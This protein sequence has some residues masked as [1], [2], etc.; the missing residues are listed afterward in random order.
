MGE[1]NVK[2]TVLDYESGL[3]SRQDLHLLLLCAADDVEDMDSFVSDVP[4][5][6]LGDFAAYVDQ[7]MHGQP[8]T[9]VGPVEVEG[10]RLGTAARLQAALRKI[11]KNPQTAT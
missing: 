7:Y 1:M 2:G 8:L 3:V 11:L 10:P 9:L 4:A 6:Y 5:E